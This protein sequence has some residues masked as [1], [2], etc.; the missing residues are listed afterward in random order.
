MGVK[1]VTGCLFLRNPGQSIFYNG[2]SCAIII[3]DRKLQN[4]PNK[5]NGRTREPN[6]KIAVQY[7]KPERGK[8]HVKRKIGGENGT[9]LQTV[10]VIP[11]QDGCLIDSVHCTF[12]SAE[13]FGA[14]FAELVNTL[15]VMAG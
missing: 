4:L 14:S 12:E 7:T 8:R 9:A 3:L 5:R 11:T 1:L 15:T 2:A 10:Y 6:A 13:G